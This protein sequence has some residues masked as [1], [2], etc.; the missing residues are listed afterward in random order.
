MLDYT[1]STNHLRSGDR[2]L[3]RLKTVDIFKLD[4][5]FSQSSL[6]K[7]M[8]KEIVVSNINTTHPV[9]KIVAEYVENIESIEILKEFG[10]NYNQ[11]Y[12]IEKNEV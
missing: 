5:I 4:G 11:S 8:S 2:S 9:G 6:T 12:Y 3:S 7:A 10:A 1:F